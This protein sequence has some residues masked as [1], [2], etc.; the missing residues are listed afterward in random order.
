MSKMNPSQFVR[1]VR[2]EVSKV[3]WATRKETLV[4][5]VMVFIFVMMAAVFFFFVDR[6][7]AF[8]VRLILGLG[9]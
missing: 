1:E 4:A 9:N 6:L 5:T 8:G 2:Q 7:M 3:T